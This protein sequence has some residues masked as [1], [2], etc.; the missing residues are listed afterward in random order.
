MSQTGPILLVDDDEDD[1]EL[2]RQVLEDEQIENALL[3][4]TD[5][6]QVLEYLESTEEPA[7]LILSDINMPK[8]GGLELKK[9]INENESLRKKSI[10]FILFTTTAAQHAV[11]QAY[12]LSVQGFFVKGDTMQELARLVK[13]IVDYWKECRH[14]NYFPADSILSRT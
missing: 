10:P 5:G 12:D 13:L 3:H 7:F 1:F 11:R 4:F 8:I 14:P 2:L 6:K 9:L